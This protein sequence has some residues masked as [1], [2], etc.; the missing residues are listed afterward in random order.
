MSL[1]VRGALREESRAV[2]R[3]DRA[4]PAAT[5]EALSA[6]VGVW[7]P[8][9]EAAP[10]APAEG[11]SELGSAAVM[12]AAERVESAPGATGP[13]I[14]LR[15]PHISIQTAVTRICESAGLRYNW[16]RSYEGTNPRCR[17]YISVQLS[18]TPLEEALDEVV[19]KNG[20]RYRLK[21]GEVWLEL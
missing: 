10:A 16:R 3:T 6:T 15:E 2:D 9:R 14:T 18:D 17:G 12:Q 19:V 21:D 13:R 4:P 1:V 7:T 5:T 20:L 8:K 11:S